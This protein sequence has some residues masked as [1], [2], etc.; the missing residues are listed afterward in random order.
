MT[1]R[2]THTIDA[3]GKILGRLA[4]QIAILLR[5]KHKRNFDPSK[6]AG[7]FVIVKNVN[8]LK[9]TGKKLKQK[10]Y[11]RHSEY[12]GKEKEIPLEKLFKERPTEVFKKAVFGM[13]PKNKLRARMI[14]RLKI[15]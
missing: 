4:S 8:G 2:K 15:E 12:L 9:F 3:T 1:E 11:F 5:G 7:D 6:D 14:K 10:K 13:L